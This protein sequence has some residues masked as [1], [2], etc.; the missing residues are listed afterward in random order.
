MFH[1]YV[2]SKKKTKSLKLKHK[3]SILP[4]TLLVPAP[5]FRV[6]H[7]TSFDS[8]IDRSA[9]AYAKQTRLPRKSKVNGREHWTLVVSHER[10]VIYSYQS[11]SEHRLLIGPRCDQIPRLSRNL[12][13]RKVSVSLRARKRKRC[14]V[15]LGARA[16]TFARMVMTVMAMIVE[17][18]M[19]CVEPDD[20]VTCIGD[21]Y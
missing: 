13:G 12:C 11:D 1:Y 18:W 2:A 8:T 16:S 5:N 19:N 6:T 15:K 17:G 10:H 3:F 21:P 9:V 4:A 14:V 20:R 7:G